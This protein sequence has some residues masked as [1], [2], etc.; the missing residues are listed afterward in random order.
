M[1]LKMTPVSHSLNQSIWPAGPVQVHTPLSS[2][3][4]NHQ[5]YADIASAFVHARQ[6][7]AVLDQYPGTIPADLATAYRVQDLAIKLWPDRI[8]GWK[9]GMING[10]MA[11]QHASNRLAGPIFSKTIQLAATDALTRFAIIEGG[12]AAVEAE[13][14]FV[15]GH[16]A[17]PNKL[18]WTHDEACELVSSVHAG[19]EIAG[20]PFP[21]INDFGPTVIV[22]DFGN[23]AGLIVGK[24][25]ENWRQSLQGPWRCSTSIDGVLIGEG[26]VTRLPG[27]AIESLRFLLELSA[28]RG[29]PLRQ[30]QYVSSGAITG[31][32]S[33]APGQMARM[34]FDT[35]DVITC[36]AVPAVAD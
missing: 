36:L 31:V 29:Y 25:I 18:H 5:S 21:G 10:E 26:D 30:G 19:V 20:S 16:D 8:S 14:V 2:N 15:I 11:V 3:E 34:V 27:G 7:A 22:S 28:R 35:T 33:I 32:H 12:F 17:P 13:V 9:V 24:S 6:Q 23:N 4:T 1:P